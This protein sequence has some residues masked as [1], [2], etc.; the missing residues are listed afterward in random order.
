VTAR[1]RSYLAPKVP[2]V[3]VVFWVIKLLTTGI[4]ETASDFLGNWNLPAAGV[5][6]VGGFAAAL[7]WQTRAESYHPVRYWVTVLMV[8]VFGTMI[9]DGPHVALGSPYYV[10]ALIYL[11]LLCALLIWWHRSEG[12][13]SV[14]SIVT[15]RRERFYWGAVLLT[16]G[17]GTALGDTTATTLNLGY[18]WSVALFGALIVVPVVAWR[19][20]DGLAVARAHGG[21]GWTTGVVT[22][23][24]LLLFGALVAYVALT[25]SDEEGAHAAH[26]A[27]RD[28]EDEPLPELELG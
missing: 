19:L 21:L 7:W 27:G 16:F 4:G 10:D 3:F 6:G 13:L 25:H 8:A 2:E 24:G 12:T 9:A 23:I 1:D 18:W 14:H 17:L 22:A 15:S 28:L 26:L 5:I 11:T 20:G